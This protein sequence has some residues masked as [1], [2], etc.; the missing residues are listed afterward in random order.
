MRP[1][2]A[3]VISHTFLL[4]LLKVFP[5]QADTLLGGCLP[6]LLL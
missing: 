6:I 1:T 2:V 4:Q 5:G 3:T